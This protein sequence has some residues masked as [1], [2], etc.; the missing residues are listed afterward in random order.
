MLHV[1]LLILKI[2]LITVLVL[3]GIALLLLLLVLFVPVRYRL[4]ADKHE[5]VLARI[6][7]SFM[8]F[9]LCFK[10][11]YD[12]DGFNYKLKLFGGT[13]M[14][15]QDSITD[16]DDGNNI[17]EKEPKSKNI[18]R[19]EKKKDYV[20]T[21]FERDISYDEL[22]QE[23]EEFL[24]DNSDFEEEKQGIFKKI[25]M[26]MDKLISG[27][28]DKVS[29]MLTKVR[30]MKDKLEEYK[31]FVRRDETQGAIAAVKKGLLKLLKH[32]KPTY[33]KGE[34]IYGAGNP[35]STGQQLGY[36]SVLFPLYYNKIDITPD[37]SQKV[38]MGY[39]SLK[40]RIRLINLIAYGLQVLLNKNM[41]VTIKRLKKMS[42]GRKNG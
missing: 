9:V 5:S 35:A 11:V 12:A 6:K 23:D 24:S 22:E 2:L 30:N 34:L 32:L 14:T 18:Q 28:K 15:N 19:I 13:L 33:I 25:G 7:I 41:M 17:Q 39:I 26:F 8:G 10:A 42:G 16:D 40:G 3:L 27:I 20:D 31:R 38:L 37:F 29:A 4:Y 21:A 1:L 36:M